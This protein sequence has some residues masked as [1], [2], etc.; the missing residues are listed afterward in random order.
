MLGSVHEADDAVQE[1][2]LRLNRSDVSGVDNLRGWLTT[3]VARVSLDMLRSRKSRRE[4][5]L[6]EHSTEPV[7]TDAPGLDPEEEAVLADSVGVA[8]LVVLDT[9]APAE[10][11]AFVLHDLF[12][13]P[14]DEIAPIV[15]RSSM[16]TRQLASRARRRVRQDGRPPE[17][18]APVPDSDRS[19]QG[20][21]VDAFL[22]AARGGNFVALL[23]VLDPEVVLRADGVAVQLS[24]DGRAGDTPP[25]DP[26]V[27]GATAVAQKFYGRTR[28]AQ[29]ALVEG[30]PGL[31]WAPAGEPR[32]VLRFTVLHGKISAMDLIAD[33]ARVHE[34]DVVFAQR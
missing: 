2:W 5:P 24:G 15:G 29:P 20:E 22:A 23:A 33:P 16:A 18:V 11:V 4:E 12:D 26:E 27:R 32:A 31:A 28:A 30:A 19:R 17:R 6:D 10:R 13:L 21:I 3:V 14:F 34:L 9:L 1:A 8:L 7:A 25:L